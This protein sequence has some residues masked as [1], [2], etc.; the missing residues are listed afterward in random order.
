MINKRY[1]IIR[2]IGEG[3]SKVFLC[4]DIFYS[5]EKFAIKILSNKCDNDEKESFRNEYFLLRRF[6]HPNII[7]PYA[8]GTISKLSQEYKRHGIEKNDLFLVTEYFEGNELSNFEWGNDEATLKKIIKEIGVTLY[9]LH[10]SN[11]IYFDLKPENILIRKDEKN[12]QIKFIDFGFTTYAAGMIDT[13]HRGTPQ[14]IAPEI[15]KKS[16]VDFRVDLYSFGVLIYQLIYNKLPFDRKTALEYYKAHLEEKVTFGKTKYPPA[17]MNAVKKLLSKEPADRYYSVLSF[18]GSAEISLTQED[19][20]KF[21]P[22]LQIVKTPDT[23][24]KI[25][26][27]LDN[28]EPAGEILMIVGREGAGKTTILQQLEE[29]YPESILITNQSSVS[30]FNFWSRF[31]TQILYNVSVYKEIDHSIIQYIENHLNSSDPNFISELKSILGKISS[32]SRF[33]LLIDDVHL[34]DDFSLEILNQ[35]MPILQANLVHVIIAGEKPGEEIGLKLNNV[36]VQRTESL[37]ENQISSLMNESFSQF[38]DRDLLI[39]LICKYTDLFPLNI[40]S[41]ISDLIR[42]EILEFVHEGPVIFLDDEQE[43]GLSKLS[44][45][46]I[47]H[48][49]SDLSEEEN[50]IV[51][52]VSLFESAV[53]EK[54]LLNLFPECS[55]NQLSE[56]ITELRNKGVFARKSISIAIKFNSEAIKKYCYNKISDRKTLHKYVA[57]KLKYYPEIDSVEIANHYEHAE[58][59]EESYRILEKEIKKAESLSAYDFEK[60]LLEKCLTYPLDKHENFRIKVQLADVN[61]RIGN[62]QESLHIAEKIQEGNSAEGYENR[63]NFIKAKSL[64]GL[65]EYKKSLA[66]YLR[67][68]KKCKSHDEKLQILSEVAGIHLDLNQYENAKRISSQIIED[69]SATSSLLGKSYNLLGLIDYYSSP[70]L[71]LAL[72]YFQKALKF[73]EKD[74]DL[75]QVAG[76]EVNISNILYMQGE[77]EK[78][79]KHWSKALQINKSVGN[80][81]QEA[82]NLMNLGIYYFDEFNV[83]KALENYKRAYN[84][85]ISVGNKLGAGLALSNLAESYLEICEYD[86]AYRSAL[87]AEEIFKDLQNSDEQF[88]VQFILGKIYFRLNLTDDLAK[89]LVKLEEIYGDKI[90]KRSKISY[91][92]VANSLLDKDTSSVS[93]PKI[94]NEFYDLL[95]QEKDSRLAAYIS[96]YYVENLIERGSYKDAKDELEK[97]VNNKSYSSHILLSAWFKYLSGILL[98]EENSETSGIHLI[99]EAFTNLQ[100]Q[101]INEVTLKILVYLNNYYFGRGN[102]SISEKYRAYIEEFF[103]YILTQTETN[104]IKKA[105]QKIRTEMKAYTK[106]SENTSN[107]N[108]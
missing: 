91:L 25:E 46:N 2:R 94:I 87:H 53:N 81:E 36:I 19:K 34:L 105:I 21:N 47:V 62:L 32:N 85:F 73:Y 1:K 23:W 64:A 61:L 70:D 69:K 60:S 37:S 66:I 48:L 65:G 52:I 99:Q 83:E 95:V 68:E 90:G 92:K 29:K 74:K 4:E 84:I 56:Y 39:E 33:V 59:F 93:E 9:Y 54:L 55:T 101:S 80:I 100:N 49:I 44:E 8:T 28:S 15:L 67:E 30:Q 14:Y 12:I 38:G 10:N 57:D 103:D 3:R 72:D 17:L 45:Q 50:N 11:Y 102:K 78:A 104:K 13:T 79:L 98:E 51:Q 42:N 16:P 43:K 7:A 31:V 86:A 77:R 18:F 82:N 63:L 88:E 97:L 35:V 27:Y 71:K 26:D 58:E 22:S 40:K 89:L 106:S 6:D 41:F 5:D 76:M 20:I 96:A 108:L 107:P 24:E 75:M